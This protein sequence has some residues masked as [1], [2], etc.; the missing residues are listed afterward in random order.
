ML[1]HGKKKKMLKA[2]MHT[3]K[4]EKVYFMEIKKI[5]TKFL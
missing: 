3:Q 2:L 5:Y 1:S 4:D